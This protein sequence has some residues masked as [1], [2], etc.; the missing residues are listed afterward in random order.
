MITKCELRK[1]GNKPRVHPNGFIQLD[2]D[3]AR[4][5]HVWHP[6]L[7][8]RQKT[9]SPVHDHIFDFDSELLVGRLV[10]V[11]YLPK[12][13]ASGSHQ[14]WQVGLIAGENTKLMKVDEVRYSLYPVEVNIT[15]PGYVYH[16]EKYVLHETLTNEP[17]MTIMTKSNA[18]LTTGPNCQGA[19]V[20]VPWNEEPDND[21]RRDAVDTHILWG[22]IDETLNRC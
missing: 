2:L 5:L 20:M 22:L 6:R 16:M 14:K 9:F 8:Y 1:L 19:S 11:K 17:T 4:R 7:P 15:Q 21:F 3:A 10:N 13:N 12:E 18:E